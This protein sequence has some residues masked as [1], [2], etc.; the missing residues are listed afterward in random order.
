ML[1]VRQA[2]S[3]RDRRRFLDLPYELHRGRPSWVAPPRI[4]EAPQFDPKRNPFY[5]VADMDLFLAWDGDKVVGRIAAIDDRR[6]NEYRKE[7]VA[8]FGFFEATS[9]EVASALFERVDTWAAARG[10][11]GVRGPVN[12]SLNYTAGLQVDAF[13]TEPYFM[14]A[15]NPPEYVDYVEA[16]GFVK[17]KDL[18]CWLLDI[19]TVPVARL[20]RLAGRLQRRL[21]ITVRPVDLGR[22]R[23]ETDRLYDVYKDA[24]EDNWGFVP[25]TREEFWNLVK[26]VRLIRMVDGITIAEVDGR[27]VAWNTL[28]PDINQMLKGTNGSLLPFGWARLL[29]MNRYIDRARWVTIGIVSDY[30]DRGILP[31]MVLAMAKVCRKYGYKHAEC[32]W[33]LEDNLAPNKTLKNIG[34]TMY[35]TYRLYHKPLVPTG[36]VATP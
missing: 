35:K 21:R 17:A 24:W 36:A 29:R 3:R 11:T 10:R 16:A 1:D 34:A 15:W 31:V 27:P 2:I 13:D 26:D 30:R 22:I 23:E 7:N 32:S 28:L 6:H 4:V 8:G 9:P 33:I 18:W 14:M 5:A 12:P 25:P 19:D 20:E